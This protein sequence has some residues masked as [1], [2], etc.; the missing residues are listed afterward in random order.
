MMIG[1]A[2]LFRQPWNDHHH[3][4]L[5]QTR[6]TFRTHLIQRNCA[7]SGNRNVCVM[8][9]L[10]TVCIYNLTFF[11]RFLERFCVAEEPFLPPAQ[12]ESDPED[13]L[14]GEATA[15]SVGFFFFLAKARNS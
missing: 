15:L 3:H 1:V 4:H 13:L 14:L 7:I 2:S 8:N 6:K 12:S 11:V 10:W 5:R 9:L